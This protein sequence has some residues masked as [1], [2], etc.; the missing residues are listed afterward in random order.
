MPSL[1]TTVPSITSSSSRQG[2]VARCPLRGL[3]EFA[4][5]TLVEL[6][7]V[8]AI[9]A[10]LLAI[11]LPVLSRLRTAS[12]RAREIAAAREL[13]SAWNQYAQDSNGVVL[14]GYRSGLPAYDEHRDPIA[15]QTIGVTANRWVWRLAPYLGHNFGA[16]YLGEHERLLRELETTDTSN[17]LYQ[18]SVFPSLGL[19]SVWVGG[20]ENFGGFS[21]AFINLYGKFYV[22]RLSEIQRPSSLLVFASARGQDASPGGTGDVVE[23]YFRIRSPFFDTRTWASLY[24]DEDPASWGNLS[25]RNGGDV[26]V[27]YAD[28]HAEA[29]SP[30]SLDDMRLW[31]NGA[32]SRDWT[33]TPG[34]G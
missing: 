10:L 4:G 3:A 34:G 22:T 8:L 2:R 6:L 27:G 16:M 31:S 5:F 14:P 29:Q 25:R 17:Y 7:V 26:V 15:A 9:L 20:D 28:G 23:G 18:T 13:V 30:E 32:T 21:S 24:A 12:T 11:L 33:L 19:N 1:T